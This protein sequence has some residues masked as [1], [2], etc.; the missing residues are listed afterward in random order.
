[1]SHVYGPSN[2]ILIKK[3][4]SSLA[5]KILK[6]NRREDNTN[7]DQII[8]K[9]DENIIWFNFSLILVQF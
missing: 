1:M 9:A 5:N 4:A 2:G 6:I 3:T 8:S 7:Q